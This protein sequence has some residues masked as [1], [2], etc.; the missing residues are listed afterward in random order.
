[1]DYR[2][3]K[4]DQVKY[5][6][7]MVQGE[8]PFAKHQKRPGGFGRFLSGLGR[9]VGSLAMPFS[10]LFPPAMIGALS[11]YG[12]G[13]IGDQVQASAYSKAMQQQAAHQGQHASFPGMEDMFGGAPAY[14]LSAVQ[15]D[16]LNVL[17]ARNDLMLESAHNL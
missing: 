9:V 6:M 14:Q 7:R 1:M 11:M 16:V 8:D 13:Q 17:Y 12:I 10:L 5:E 2:S 4:P 15:S 3:I